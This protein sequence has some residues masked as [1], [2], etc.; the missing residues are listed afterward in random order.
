MAGRLG[1]VKPR[2][3]VSKMKRAGFRIDRQTGSHAVL[4]DNRGIRLVVPMHAKEM[5]RGL[6]M[7]LLKLAGLSTEHF[8]KL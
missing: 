5:K 6:L 3:F 8:R 7:D 1:S 4:L 2:Q